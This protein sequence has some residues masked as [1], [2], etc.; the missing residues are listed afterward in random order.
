[1]QV[2]SR[3]ALVS[4]GKP[5][6]VSLQY[7]ARNADIKQVDVR[8]LRGDGTWPSNGWTVSVEQATRERGQLSAGT[9]QTRSATPQRVTFEY[10]LVSRSGKLSAP[11][12]K[13]FEFAPPA[14]ITPVSYTHLDVYKRQSLA[15]GTA[16]AG[17][18]LHLG[19]HFILKPGNVVRSWLQL[20][21]GQRL[22]LSELGRLNFSGQAL[23]T[24]ASC[25]T[26]VGTEQADG[27]EVE[28]LSS[29][30]L[31]RGAG[32]VLASLWRVD[33]RATPVS[34]T[35]LD[36][37]KRQVLASLWRVNDRETA[38]FMQRFYSELAAL[39]NDA[40][41]ALHKAQRSALRSE[42]GPPHWAAFT[43]LVRR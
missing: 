14:T 24:L 10:T 17:G 2:Q 30:V 39:P 38:R 20:G 15:A 35:H 3:Q 28:G 34:Y 22:H 32:A 5:Q 25:E 33:D 12:E 6:E 29:L 21:D 1:M 16:H 27:R 13:T 18:L 11:F 42:S 37:Y 26:A 36:V 7:E 31:H 40:A 19:T 23:V 9:L 41:L 43:L 4:N 8:F